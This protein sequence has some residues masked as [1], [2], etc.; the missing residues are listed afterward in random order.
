MQIAQLADAKTFEIGMKVR[1]RQI[2]LFDLKVGSFDDG[3]KRR[4]REWA[5]LRQ[6]FRRHESAGD[7]AES[8]CH[9]VPEPRRRKRA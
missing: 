5:P 7:A 8:V 6:Q 2:D 3:A 9:R 4:H 1:N